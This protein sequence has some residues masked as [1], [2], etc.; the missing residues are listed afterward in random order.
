MPV[1]GQA[2]HA[3]YAPTRYEREGRRD[4]SS[5]RPERAE[6]QTEQPPHSRRP[7]QVRADT[8]FATELCLKVSSNGWRGPSTT[9]VSLIRRR[10]TLRNRGKLLAQGSLDQHSAYARSN[11]W[12]LRGNGLGGGAFLG[13][14]ELVNCLDIVLDGGTEHRSGSWPRVTCPMSASNPGAKSPVT[15]S[16]LTARSCRCQENN[17]ASQILGLTSSSFRLGYARKD[18]PWRSIRD[19][20]PSARKGSLIMAW[21]WIVLVSITVIGPTVFHRFL[22]IRQE[23][24]VLGGAVFTVNYGPVARIL[25]TT[26]KFAVVWAIA[27]LLARLDN[28]LWLRLWVVGP[29]LLGGSVH[30]FGCKKHRVHCLTGRPV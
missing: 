14:I 22:P 3:V 27:L 5:R 4:C 9:Q 18:D 16:H 8:I 24:T 21:E 29:P 1:C 6:Q 2:A 10:S 13:D 12:T 20:L 19:G 7:P 15:Q 17:S 11:I 25:R 26:F 28:R 23:I 30:F